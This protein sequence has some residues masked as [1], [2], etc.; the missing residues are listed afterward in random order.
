MPWLFATLFTAKVLAGLILANRAREKGLITNQAI[1]RY[2]VV[3]CGATAFL[4]LAVW[5]L[6][7]AEF[8]FSEHYNKWLFTLMAL[9]VVPFLR[10]AYAPL[11]L[12]QNRRR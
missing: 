6:V 3:W 2:L 11:A 10:P 4:V 1:H 9:F 7:P 12:A 5:L 8:V